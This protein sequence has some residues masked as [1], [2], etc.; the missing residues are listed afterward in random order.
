M[1]AHRIQ[2][3]RTAGWRLP[4]NTVK[5]DRSTRW[6][7]PYRI[8]EPVDL[9]Q[10]KRWGWVFSPQGKLIVC[11]DA[12]EAVRRFSVCVAGDEAIHDFVRAQLGGK[13]LACW[14]APGDPC[15]ADILLVLANGGRS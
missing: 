5:V 4:P 1:T 7:N 2:L 3:S 13:N 14:C 12:T 6:G 10:V 11:A 15:H 9:K 8:G